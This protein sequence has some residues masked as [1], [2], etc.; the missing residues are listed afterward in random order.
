VDIRGGKQASGP[1][2]IDLS[3]IAAALVPLGLDERAISFDGNFPNLTEL[4]L[5][6]TGARFHC[7]MRLPDAAA[8]SD[9]A[10]FS[11]MVKANAI[12]AYFESLPF[13]L[14]LLAE[15]AVFSSTPALIRSGNGTLVLSAT[16]AD[17]ESTLLNFVR[18]AA[19]K[20]GA[21]AESVQLSLTAEG[22]RAMAVRATATAKA[23]FFTATLTLTG[24]IEITDALEAR[25]CALACSGDGMIANL[26]AGALRPK[27]ALFEGRAFALRALLPT[28]NALNL[29][30]TNGLKLSAIFG[31]SMTV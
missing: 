17:I 25:L 1:M 19:E 7:E 11:R 9:P 15:D 23:M 24:R 27:L 18:S 30:T 20:Q 10:F 14:S 5:D 16:S 2:P 22:P 13:T 28:L 29:D 4:R 6:L 31:D 12:P 3:I 26:A 21:E 8:C